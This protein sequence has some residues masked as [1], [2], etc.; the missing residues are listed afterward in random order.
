[1]KILKS[2]QVTEKDQ[3]TLLCELDDAG[4]EVT[5]HKNNEEV[6]P[7]KRLVSDINNLMPLYFSLSHLKVIRKTHTSIGLH[8]YVCI[9]IH[10]HLCSM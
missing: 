6:K 7:D 2:Q 8:I 5:W 3:I 9:C 1:M 10:T 4:G